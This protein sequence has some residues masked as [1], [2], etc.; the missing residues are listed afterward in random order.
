MEPALDERGDMPAA[1][2]VPASLP[3]QW[4]PLSTSGATCRPP[5]R[6]RR[7]CRR[8]GARSRRAGRHAGRLGGA[9]VLAAA[10]E[11]ALDERGDPV[12]ASAAGRSAKRRNGARSRRAGRRG[13]ERAAAFLVAAAM[14]PALDERGDPR[15]GPGMPLRKEPQWSPL[16]TSGATCRCPDL[17]RTEDRPQ[18]SPLSTSGATGVAGRRRH[19][20]GQAAM[21]P[22]L[23]ERGDLLISRSPDPYRGPQ[24]SPLST[25][26]AT[27]ARPAMTLSIDAP[28]W[29]PLSTSG[30]TRAVGRRADRLGAAAMEPA[31]DERGDLPGALP[32]AR[33]SGRNGA[34]SRRAGRRGAPAPSSRQAGRRNGAR[35]RR[36]GRPETSQRGD[37]VEGAAMEPALDERGD[38]PCP[39]QS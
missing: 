3:P 6:C 30:A 21:E 24:W 11:P 10:M 15:T 29:S 19:L 18:W 25:S 35:S 7:P 1:S 4:S 5:R 9:G 39:R 20:Q 37:L 32:R 27:P 33:W 38:G 31:L 23:D 13:E 12:T 22:A 8:N 26:G 17:R 28:Q 34:R 16:S 2:A 14:E 36:A